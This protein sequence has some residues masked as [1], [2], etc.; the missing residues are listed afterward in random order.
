MIR[1]VGAKIPLEISLPSNWKLLLPVQNISDL[2]PVCQISA[3]KNRNSRG[4]N[5]T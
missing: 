1:I 3:V 2:F 5:K 4:I